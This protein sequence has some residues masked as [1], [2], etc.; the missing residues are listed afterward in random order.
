MSAIWKYEIEATD[1]QVINMPSG[2]E[3]LGVQ[4]QY[5]KPCI[6]AKVD[7]ECNKEE[8]EFV[9]C[10]TGHTIQSNLHLKFIGT[11]QLMEGRF[12][13]HIFEKVGEEKLIT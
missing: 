1:Y 2:A 9:L 8:R 6:W 11:F 12:V 7:P 10:G 4:V 13:G 5:G 3:I